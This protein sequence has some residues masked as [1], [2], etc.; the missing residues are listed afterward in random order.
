MSD[1]GRAKNFVKVDKAMLAQLRPM[2]EAAGVEIPGL[3]QHQPTIDLDEPI[4]DIARQLGGLCSRQPIFFRAGNLV[5]LDDKGELMPMSPE[6]FGSWVEKFVTTVRWT[7]DRGEHACTMAIDQAK[8]LLATDQFRV[9]IRELKFYFPVRLPVMRGDGAVELL[10]P[11]Y[12][13]DTCSWTEDGIRYDTDLSVNAGRAIVAKYLNEW[14]YADRGAERAEGAGP[15]TL[16]SSRDAAVILAGMLGVFCRPMFGPGIKRPMAA[17][18]GNQPGTGKT[19]LCK[20]MMA[21]VYGLPPEMTLPPNEEKLE[22]LLESTALGM[23]PFLFL[24]DVGKMMRSNALNKF[25]TASVHGG[26][27]LYTQQTFAVPNVTQ[28]FVTG[29]DLPIEANLRRRVI[30]SEL[31]LS[32]EVQ[33]REFFFEVTDSLLAK[34][35]TRGE[36]LGAMWALVRHWASVS[37]ELQGLSSRRVIKS[38]EVYC[39][40]IGGILFSLGWADPF[41]EAPGVSGGDSESR[42]FKALLVAAAD[43]VMFTPHEFKVQDMVDLARKLG[44]LE[45]FVGNESD[46][47][48]VKKDRIRFGRALAVHRGRTYQ[49][50]DGKF[51]Q[52]GRRDGQGGSVYPCRVEDK[53]G[54]L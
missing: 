30:W 8:K 14:P 34:D 5:A 10:E 31:F 36:L 47:D 40:V 33:N 12:D 41:V 52:F 43:T 37:G 22:R 17:V 46:G 9:L 19:T 49:R 6:R 50:T 53:E 27:R 38:F 39:R 16:E 24:D 29:N 3:I 4:S 25:V 23:E 51:F 1:P 21:P 20:L 44:I 18:S 13:D 45:F 42:E 7:K 26:T 11:G 32:G 48:L 2:A 15:W 35:E 28:V 54:D